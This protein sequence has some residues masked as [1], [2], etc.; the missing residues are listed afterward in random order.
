MFMC[1]TGKSRNKETRNETT[2]IFKIESLWRSC[3]S[4][5][6]LPLFRSVQQWTDA[7]GK[8]REGGGGGG[9]LSVT[10]SEHHMQV[11]IQLWLQIYYEGHHTLGSHSGS[12][13]GLG[14]CLDL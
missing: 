11:Y 13:I 10:F 4:R 2:L 9:E 12:N 7:A 6:S 5:V 3:A 14:Y 1:C 8:K